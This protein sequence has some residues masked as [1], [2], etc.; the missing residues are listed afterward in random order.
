MSDYLERLG[1]TLGSVPAPPQPLAQPDRP[2]PGA[3]RL[4]IAGSRID[5]LDFLALGGCALQVTVGKRN[6]GLGRMAKPSQ[7][8]LLELEFLQLAPACIERQRQLGNGEL[9]VTLEEAREQKQAQL[10]AL[11]FNATLGGEEYYQFWGTQAV[12]V[13]YP[14]ATGS[15]VISA[16]EAVN[17]LVRRWLAGDYRA[18]NLAFEIL[19]SEVR[20]GDGGMLLRALS[21]QAAGLA[22]A[23]DMIDRRRAQSPLC[24]QGLRPAAADILPRVVERFFIGGVQP[25]AAALGNRAYLLLPPV[26]ELETLLEEALPDT[27]RHWREQRESRLRRFS[28]APRVHVAALQQL[29]AS[30]QE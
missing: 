4:Q 17:S 10:A 27:Y 8:L 26:R 15:E 21:R 6:T 16:L 28:D 22:V 30:C 29:L 13:D 11:I 24:H 9:A 23:N 3:L 19:L 20:T 1:R 18:D 2:R 7:R 5:M 12:A 14:A 25:Y